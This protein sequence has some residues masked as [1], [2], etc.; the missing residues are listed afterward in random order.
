MINLEKIKLYLG[1]RT[2][3]DEISFQVNERDRI[4]LVGRN[5]A[6]KSTLLKLIHGDLSPDAGQ[7][8]RKGGLRIGF[9]HQDIEFE[10]GKT[11]LEEVQTAFTDLN[12]LQR[13]IDAINHQLASRTD[14][15]SEAYM[16]LIEDLN[17][18][19][20]HHHLLG[21]GNTQAQTEQILNGLGFRVEEFDQPT[22]RFSGG[23]RMRIELAKLL[24]RQ[25]D[26][27]LLDE[28]TNH[29]DI[30]SILWFESFLQRYKGAVILISHDRQFLDNTT[31]RTLEL[32]RGKAYDFNRPYSRYLK[33]RAE[34]RTLQRN[35]KK[36]QD[37]EI[38]RT[39][40]LIERFRY[41]ATKSALAQ[42]L[43]KDLDKLERI[44]VA[45]EDTV[46]MNVELVSSR[47]SGK[48]VLKLEGVGKRFGEKT[49][50]QGV[51]LE[52][53]RGEKVAFVGRNGQGK[54]TL[55][56][57]IAVSLSHEGRVKCGH[58]VDLGYLAQD[59][60]D[61]LNPEASLLQEVEEVASEA[62]RPKARD[63]LGAFLFS[64]DAVEKRVKVLSGGERGRLALCKLLVQPFNTLVLDEPT[65]H[66]DIASKEVL[67]NALSQF[68]GSLILVS[69]DREFLKGLTHKV[70]EFQGGSIKTHLGD[71]DFFLSERRAH[72]MRDW[73]ADRGKPAADPS[74]QAH[75]AGSPNRKSDKHKKNRLAKLERQID[76]LQA[77]LN[78]LDTQLADPDTFKERSRDPQFFQEYERKRQKLEALN[79]E[80]EQ[81][82]LELGDES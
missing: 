72:S 74:P 82:Y 33:L 27:L 47:R 1:G 46:L 68:E 41:K 38:K 81:C 19:T 32:C 37:R 51:D 59:Q 49:V 66:L 57:I 4:G 63:L 75:R 11:V 43:I 21:G 3:F 64:G 13:E 53:A 73:E 6:G 25:D 80:W 48:V 61:Q 31:Q 18:L 14:Y 36:N 12:Q 56:R 40:K 28:P 10:P 22:E 58:N 5:G 34:Q 9:L 67:K 62:M 39:E 77:T 52:V 69:H 35:A 7:L 8:H 24:L 44:E 17:H 42:K 65:N 76:E 55:A 26:L 16:R 30:E 60:H 71:I 20:E 70:I 79:A 23:W 78:A 54:T 15:E 2:L 50:L 45:E 29:L